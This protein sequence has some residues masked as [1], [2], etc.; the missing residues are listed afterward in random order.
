MKKLLFTLLFA[1]ATFMLS[2]HNIIPQPKQIKYLS[3]KQIKLKSIDVKV[4]STD[5]APSEQ[6]TL[7]TKGGYDF[8]VY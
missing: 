4:V 2:A 5:G 1:L 8:N 7:S 6:Y 3:N